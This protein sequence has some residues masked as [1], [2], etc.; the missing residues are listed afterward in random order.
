[1]L[2]HVRDHLP[3][4]SLRMLGRDAPI[5]VEFVLDTGFDGELVLPERVLRD[6]Q[7]RADGGQ[8]TFLPGVGR[9]RVSRYWAHVE[10]QG[11]W[12]E[13]EVLHIEGR[14]LLGTKR[15]IRS[16]RDDRWR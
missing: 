4:V 1:M 8:T 12:L 16:D 10:W 6:L 2:G 9:E 13:V 5:V 3:R 11:G 7:V 14:P 15:Y